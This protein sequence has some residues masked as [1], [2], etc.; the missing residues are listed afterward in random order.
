VK[1][2]GVRT[3]RE[4]GE[5]TKR[6]NESGRQEGLVT[7]PEEA[8]QPATFEHIRREGVHQKEVLAWRNYKGNEPPMNLPRRSQDNLR[9]IRGEDSQRPQHDLIVMQDQKSSMRAISV[10]R[11]GRMGA[12]LNKTKNLIGSTFQ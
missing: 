12:A 8:G 3:T 10:L 11:G 6:G 2:F 5:K 4:K 7:K 9:K 1:T